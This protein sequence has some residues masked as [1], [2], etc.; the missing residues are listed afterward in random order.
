[1]PALHSASAARRPRRVLDPI[2]R[3]SEVLFGLIMVLTF[4]GSL[5]VAEGGRDAVRTMLVGALGCNLAWGIIDALFYLMGCIAERGEGLRTLHAVRGEADAGLGQRLIADALPPPVAA[6]LTPEELESMR[7][8]LMQLPEPPAAP[9]L[10]RADWLGSLGVFLL[11]FLSTFPVVVPFLI[12]REAATAL[13]VS[14]AV[15]V[16]MLFLSGFA[17][18]RCVGRHPWLMGLGMLV[19]GGALVG[20]TMAL[21]G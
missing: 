1:M 19:L 10:Q 13:R 8:R 12:F 5:S 4:T 14:N 3:I 21:G 2:D 16:A 17:F 18:G 15:A 20:L 11:V 7:S 6:V 9:G